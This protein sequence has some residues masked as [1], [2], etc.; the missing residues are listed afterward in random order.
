MAIFFKD[1][2][3][4]CEAIGQGRQDVI[5][6]KGGIHEGREG[7][8]FKHED[9]Y[10]FPTL[11]HAQGDMVKEP[12]REMAE[13]LTSGSAWEPGDTLLVKYRCK[14]TKAETLTDWSEVQALDSRHIWKEEI[15]RE[16]FDW[17]GKGMTEGSIHVAYLEVET[18]EEPIV[19]T[20]E[21]SM[22]GCRSWLEIQI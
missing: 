3:V 16:R 11:F 6:R 2:A 13:L 4:V 10:L 17:A 9:F 15:I 12:W 8:S 14:V 19:L 7:F 1:W 22:G 18:L 21:K 20:Y 5:L